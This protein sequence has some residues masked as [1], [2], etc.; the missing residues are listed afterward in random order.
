[1][2]GRA[3]AICLPV[4]QTFEG[5]TEG[6]TVDTYQG[7]WDDYCWGFRPNEMDEP[8]IRKGTAVSVEVEAA[9]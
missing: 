1:M 6:H 3:S 2:L 5:L 7:W 8:G 9:V 4:E